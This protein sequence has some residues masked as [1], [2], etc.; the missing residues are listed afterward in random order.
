MKNHEVRLDAQRVRL[1]ACF[2]H[3]TDFA[4]VGDHLPIGI[5]P[6]GRAALVRHMGLA[7]AR[8]DRS[9]IP[10]E[11]FVRTRL[12]GVDQTVVSDDLGMVIGTDQPP[13]AG[14]KARSAAGE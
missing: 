6:T 13:S 14:V 7:A 3:H 10:R 8:P 5:C 9:A 1:L 11:T 12:V 2:S 4:Q